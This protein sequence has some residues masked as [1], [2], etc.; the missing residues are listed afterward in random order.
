MC[1]VAVE[2]GIP[3]SAAIRFT[4]RR[5]TGSAPMT[6]ARNRNPRIRPATATTATAKTDTTA[7]TTAAP[8]TTRGLSGVRAVHSSA[9]AR[10]LGTLGQQSSIPALE[11]RLVV[12]SESR[13]VNVILG[14]LAAR[15]GGA[16][17]WVGTLRVT[18]WGALAMGVTAGVGALFHIAV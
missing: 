2:V 16:P 17:M 14:A 5:W 10:A 6:T 8:A 4:C 1:I 11:A 7:A 12:E 13:V 9:A 3:R 18:F 15:I